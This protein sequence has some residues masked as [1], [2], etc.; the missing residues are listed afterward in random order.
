MPRPL[1][2]RV[3]FLALAIGTIVLGLL[4]HSSAGIPAGVR[5]KLGD[6]LWAAMVV[7][8]IGVL[9]PR[10]SV[11]S[12]SLAALAFS[13]TV[14]ASQLCHAPWLEHVRATTLGRF[15]LGSGFDAGDLLAYTLGVLAAA[16]GETVVRRGRERANR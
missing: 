10:A 5:D 8:W 16:I 13:W 6:G 1:R 7:W 9:V 2:D 15:V 11:R 3:V 4:V 12:R 14:E